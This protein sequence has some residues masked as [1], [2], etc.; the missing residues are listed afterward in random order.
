LLANP[1]RKP[2]AAAVKHRSQ[3]QQDARCFDAGKTHANPA[4][5]APMGV[6]L[7]YQGGL[8]AGA[9]LPELFEELEDIARS[10]GW[11][12]RR[13]ALDAENPVFE[14]V[15]LDPGDKTESLAFLFDREGRLRNLVDLVCGQFEPDPRCSYFVSVKTQYG[16]IRTHLWIVGLLR[17]L[18]SKYLPDLEVNDEGGYWESGDAAELDRR[19][20]FLNEKMADLVAGLSQIPARGQSPSEL[21]DEIEA[22]FEGRRTGGT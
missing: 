22:Y 3:P 14:G 20:E 17:Y 13:I 9:S 11:P 21:A 18:K 2:L 16:E 4:A 7:H 15:I 12:V 1:A 10:M 19:R 6:S 8:G 5:S